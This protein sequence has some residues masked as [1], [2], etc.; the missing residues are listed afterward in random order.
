[1]VYYE[2][3]KLMINVLSLAEVI[4]N[5]VLHYY[6]VLKVIIANEGLLFTIKK[7]LSIVFYP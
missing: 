4:I 2:P 1:M 3:I 7:K 5:V 6:G